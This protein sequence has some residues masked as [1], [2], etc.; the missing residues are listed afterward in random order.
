MSDASVPAKP[1]ARKPSRAAGAIRPVG[2]AIGAAREG[3]KGRIRKVHGP[4]PNEATNLLIADVAMRSVMILM[5]RSMER[6]LL[7]ARF[8][9][10]KAR[11]II[12]GRPKFRAMATAAVARQATKSVPGMVLLGGGLLA[13]VAFDRGRNRR[14]ARLAGEQKLEKMAKN[15]EEQ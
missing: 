15:A 6:G 12:E 8:D 3:V 10:E 1:K 4:S 9:P 7:R 2:K 5:R 14:N 11:A 13:K